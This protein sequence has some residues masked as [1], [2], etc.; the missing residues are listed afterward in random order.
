[1]RIAIAADHAGVRLKAAIIHLCT[2]LGHVIEDFGT[3]DET[4]CDYPDLIRP[5]ALAVA[6]GRCERGIVIGGS[7]NG[8][9]IVANRIAGI[10]C[11]LVW[12]EESARLTRQHNDANVIALGQRLIP[13]DLAFRCVR[14]FLS[15]PFDG[16]RHLARIRKIDAL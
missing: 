10:R 13:E 14:L 5:A 6:D 11:G 1:M 9:A 15:E 4:P 16:G 12:S 3:H 2:D 7:G 8:E